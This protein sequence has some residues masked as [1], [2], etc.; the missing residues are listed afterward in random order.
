MFEKKL[1]CRTSMIVVGDGED[2]PL[3]FEIP[4]IVTP[5]TG[6]VFFVGEYLPRY[7]EHYLEVVSRNFEFE[8]EASPYVVACM[9]LFEKK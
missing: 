7:S 3:P 2:Y 4:D 5:V 6:D 1:R 9:I 8:P